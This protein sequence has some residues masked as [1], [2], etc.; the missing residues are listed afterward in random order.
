MKKASIFVS[1]IAG[2]LMFAMAQVP[3][4][5]QVSG[6][7]ANGGGLLSLLALAQTL[8]NRLVPF[9]IGIAVLAFFWFLIKL[10]WTSDSAE[11]KKTAVQGIT[12][13]IVALFLMVAVWGVI[14]LLA[15]MLG[16]GVAGGIPAPTLPQPPVVAP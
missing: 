11:S 14:G 5:T 16:V 7:I 3:V 9:A 2:N 4:G 12:Y 10:V 13:S 1:I 8:I 15:N 6:T